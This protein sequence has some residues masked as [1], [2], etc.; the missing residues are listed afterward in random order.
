MKFCYKLMIMFFYPSTLYEP[1]IFYKN[2][3]KFV[4]LLVSGCV[5]G[6]KLEI[7]L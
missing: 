6:Q 2:G 4:S 7:E 5:T 3:T 1:I